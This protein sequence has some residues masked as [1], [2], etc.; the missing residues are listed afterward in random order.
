MVNAKEVPADMLISELAKY[1]K[2][3]VRS[4]NPPEWA[5]FVK[6]GPNKE[7]VPE[8]PEWWYTRAASIMRKLYVA[9]RPVGIERLRTAYGSLK[10]RGSAPPHFRK[11]AGGHIRKILQQLEAAGLVTTINR[12]GRTLTPKGT[13]L[14]NKVANEVFTKLI[15]ERPDLR[16]YGG[17]KS[18]K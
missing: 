10:D 2:E 1:L 5:I 6:T 17:L 8:D 4:V 14:L 16:K 11:S 15:S 13:S 18:G 7:R 9:G 12:K 3:H